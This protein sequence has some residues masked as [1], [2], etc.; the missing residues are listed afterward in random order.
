MLRITT[1][2]SCSTLLSSRARHK[3]LQ[4]IAACSS[5]RSSHNDAVLLPVDTLDPFPSELAPPRRVDIMLP[6]SYHTSP[7][8]TRFPV[9]YM[10][11]GQNAIDPATSFLSV[12]W[13]LDEALLAGLDSGSLREFIA[14]LVWNTPQRLQEYMPA[15]ALRWLMAQE[16]CWYDRVEDRYYNPTSNAY[17][18]MLDLPGRDQTAMMGS[19]MGGLAA[20]YAL[21]RHPEVFG[22]AAC[23]ST[24]WVPGGGLPV[25][26]LAQGHI[27]D[28]ATH[29]LYFDHG[30]EGLDAEYGPYQKQVDQ[31]CRAAGYTE[32]VNYQSL[33][34][35]G[36]AH[37]ELAWRKRLIS[38]L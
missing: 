27:P 12:D 8:T 13:G 20:L 32:G 19:S 28:P 1:S 38:F 34:F 23:L 3:Q 2:C 37:N 16:Q 17:L 31:L 14:V 9:L 26:W 25:A 5:S 21:Q 35:S 15:E 33:V 24:H 36:E 18:G 10:H 11:D 4:R 7:P 29:R 6:P 30:S 22:A